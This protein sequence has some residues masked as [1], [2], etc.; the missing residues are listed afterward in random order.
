MCEGNRN[1]F[2]YEED[3]NYFMCERIKRT[4]NKGQTRNIGYL[5]AYK[6][7][8]NKLKI[9]Y[10]LCMKSDT[11]DNHYGKELAIDM[12]ET[13]SNRTEHTFPKSI[14]KDLLSFVGRCIRYYKIKDI[15]K[16]LSLVLLDF[17]ITSLD[18]IYLRT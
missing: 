11:F 18:K 9:G 5:V 7:Y 15:R 8:Y 1:N 16:E 3:R 17:I 2:V 4:N 14:E 13:L 6:T 10:S 12:A